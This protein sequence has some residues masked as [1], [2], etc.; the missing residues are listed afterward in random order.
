MSENINLI[1]AAQL[2]LTEAKEVEVLCVDNGELKRKAAANLGGGG[3]YV[4]HAPADSI[5]V[6]EEPGDDG[7]M[8]AYISNVSYD[9]FIDVL[10][11]GGSLWL[12][13]TAV[14]AAMGM[15]DTILYG[16]A[17]TWTYVT[18]IGIV[19]RASIAAP[20]DTGMQVM[21]LNVFFTNGTWTPETEE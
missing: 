20:A 12:D 6:G 3:G 13:F 14:F 15:T 11:A 8:N 19:V 16:S 7:S 9:E 17:V 10:L 2:P 18:G 1:P 5:Q 21:P 4:I